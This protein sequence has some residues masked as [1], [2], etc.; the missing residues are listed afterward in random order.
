MVL[1]VKHSFLPSHGFQSVQKKWALKKKI[2]SIEE[3]EFPHLVH[4]LQ[5]VNAGYKQTE[6]NKLHGL[7]IKC[8][9]L[10]I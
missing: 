4:A 10:F 3:I 7:L 1:Y 5:S 6:A 2:N 8:T 9:H